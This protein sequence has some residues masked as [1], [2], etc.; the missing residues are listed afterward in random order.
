MAFLKR[1]VEG[2]F[3]ANTPSVEESIMMASDLMRVEMENG[4]F[5]NALTVLEAKASLG[6]PHHR[7][8]F[9]RRAEFLR[10]GLFVEPYSAVILYKE[11]LAVSAYSTIFATDRE[12][13][14]AKNTKEWNM[15]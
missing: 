9:P 15:A 14:W 2:F 8:S 4:R 11:G 10:N 5:R 6:Y 3:V 1:R 13:W 12:S 7:Y